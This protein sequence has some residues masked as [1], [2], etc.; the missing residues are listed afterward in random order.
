MAI[1]TAAN[2]VTNVFNRDVNSSL[3]TAAEIE[4]AEWKYIRGGLMLHYTNDGEDIYEAIIDDMGD[5]GDYE[6][7]GGYLQKSLSFYVAA[8]VLDTIAN[9][10]ETRG[11]FEYTADSANKSQTD[12]KK[13]IK[14]G[15]MKAG[16]LWFDKALNWINENMANDYGDVPETDAFDWVTGLGYNTEIPK[17]VNVI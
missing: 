16:A 15:Y 1:E 17:R 8:S 6:T 11:V 10:V 7:V 13:S 9:G 2:I 12:E 3:I 5:G 4:A 14:A